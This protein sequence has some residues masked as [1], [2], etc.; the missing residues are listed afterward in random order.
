MVA[1]T[2]RSVLGAPPDRPLEERDD[3]VPLIADWDH[4]GEGSLLGCPMVTPQLGVKDG[5]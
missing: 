5:R 3:R 4:S 2:G 1:A